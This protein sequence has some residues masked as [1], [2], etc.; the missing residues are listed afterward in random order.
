M[1][2]GKAFQVDVE[3]VEGGVTEEVEEVEEVVVEVEAVDAVDALAN[4]VGIQERRRSR[5]RWARKG[6]VLLSQMV[7]RTRRDKASLSFKPPKKQG[8]T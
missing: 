1:A 6:S 5:Q 2:L 3:I 4:L 7:G 8:P